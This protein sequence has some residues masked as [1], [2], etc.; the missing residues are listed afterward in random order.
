[1][2]ITPEEI[3]LAYSMQ[4]ESKMQETAKRLY[5]IELALLSLADAISKEDG[6]VPQHLINLEIELYK[7][8]MKI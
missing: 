4:H 5:M 7:R 6:T 1:M 8:G 2:P 3:A